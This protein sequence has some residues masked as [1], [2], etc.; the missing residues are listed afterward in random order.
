MSFE[1]WPAIDLKGG[2]CVRLLRGDMTKATVFSDDPGAQA[3]KFRALG[4]SRLHVVDLDGAFEGRAVNAEAVAGIRAGTDATIQLGGGIRD[5]RALEAWLERGIARAIV[6]TAALKTPEFPKEAARR[7]PGRV[8]IGID[9]RG[10][11]VTVEATELARRAEDWGAAAI[12]YTD[13]ERDGAMKGVNVAA[14]EA[15]ACALRVPVIASGGV[16]G[17]E[18]LRRLVAT[19][20]V[21]GAIVGRALYDGGLDAKAAL[22]LAEAA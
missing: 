7:H 6:G 4:F 13:I 19:G 17:L 21:A 22:A 11:K 15:L 12:V 2:R 1:I 10:G 20:V 8:V 3:A 14:T 18:D 9:A 16:S 5:M